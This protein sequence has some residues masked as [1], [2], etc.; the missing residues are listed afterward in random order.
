MIA[1]Q[2]HDIKDFMSKLLI[3]NTFDAFWLSEAAITTSVTFHID[4]VLHPDFY[5]TQDAE[6]ISS[7][8]R[9]YALWKDIKPHCFSV[10]KGK[11]TPLHFKIIF[12]LSKK[13]TEKL[14][15]G[16]HLPFSAEEVFGLF[17]NFQY[18]G[19]HITCTTGTSMKTFTLDKSLEHVWDE[20]I[21]KF[22]KQ[23]QIPYESI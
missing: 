6:L 1:L 7:E 5:D 23:Q 9:T 3:G 20:M 14:L 17:A 8:G 12:M 2:I 13:N 4:G 16:S 11:Q 10:M 15:S 21:Q 18:D 22:F 19:K